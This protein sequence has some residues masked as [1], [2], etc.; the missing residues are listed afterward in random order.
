MHACL[1][2]PELVAEICSHLYTDCVF[3]ARGDLVAFAKTSSTF[4][5]HAL[6]L[7]WK[8]VNLM[9]LLRLLPEQCFTLETSQSSYDGTKVTMRP[10]RPLRDCDLERV[11]FYIASV[12][13]LIVDARLQDATPML[14][15]AGS[16]LS[17]SLFPVLRGLQWTHEGNNSDVELIKYFL[18]PHL[19]ELRIPSA[20]LALLTSL[21]TLASSDLQLKADYAF[22]ECLRGLHRIENMTAETLDELALQRLSGLPTLRELRLEEVL[23]SD[24]PV[25]RADKGK[26]SFPSLQ[27]LFF[28]TF[29]IYCPTLFLAYCCKS[30][31]VELNVECGGRFCTT[32]E[33]QVLF[34]GAALGISHSTLKDFRFNNVPEANANTPLL[35]PRNRN[36]HIITSGSLRD[37]CCFHNLVSVYV[38]SGVG[39][40]LDDDTVLDMASSWPHIERLELRSHHGTYSPRATLRCLKSFNRFCPKLTKLCMPLG[41][42]VGVLPAV[43]IDAAPLESLRE[44]DVEASS[45]AEVYVQPVARYFAHLFPRLKM[46][47][48]IVDSLKGKKE[49]E[50]ELPSQALVSHPHWR[51][52]AR[53]LNLRE[54]EEET[55]TNEVAVMK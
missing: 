27:K 54:D 26:I 42:S 53:I 22:L 35:P 38:L 5:S 44:I 37:L 12:Q 48:T 47:E 10:S 34:H 51:R 2:I 43:L 7:V 18:N 6:P 33:V 24:L 21:S 20:S 17:E 19:T 49:R 28:S 45:L 16:R 50:G 14:A 31:L 9:D 11:L 52:V 29:F 25:F 4:S 15:G 32:E 23:I 30:P 3:P 8:S 1:R 55:Q 36:N 46:L 41:A 40:D 39:I 13:H